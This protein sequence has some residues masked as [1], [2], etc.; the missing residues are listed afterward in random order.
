MLCA[1]FEI[2]LVMPIFS[3]FKRIEFLCRGR[4]E[5]RVKSKENREK[6]KDEREQRTDKRVKMK[7]E[8]EQST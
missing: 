1:F 2:I 3:R 6:M 7:D 5:A 4:G 8:R